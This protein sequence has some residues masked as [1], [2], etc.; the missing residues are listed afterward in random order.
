M[1][2]PTDLSLLASLLAPLPLSV[3]V[4]SYADLVRCPD[5]L[6]RALLNTI[7]DK[8]R[9]GLDDCMGAVNVLGQMLIDA[10]EAGAKRRR[11]GTWMA[12]FAPSGPPC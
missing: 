10:R 7:D 11:S 8:A 5:T 4:D 2:P 9:A 6:D 3:A 12:P 1:R